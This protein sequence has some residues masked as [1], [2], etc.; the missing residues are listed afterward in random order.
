MRIYFNKI[1]LTFIVGLLSFS[2]YAINLTEV[3]KGVVHKID[4]IINTSSKDLT[5]KKIASFVN[6]FRRSGDYVSTVIAINKTLDYF[7][8]TNLDNTQ[9]KEINELKIALGQ[10]YIGLGLYAKSIKYNTEVLLYTTQ[11]RDTVLMIYSKMILSEAYMESK[12]YEKGRSHMIEAYQLSKI[13]KKYK[14]KKMV[15][16]NVAAM[17][18]KHSQPDSAIVYLNHLESLEKRDKTMDTYVYLNKCDCLL[19]QKK[20]DSALVYCN[21]F[22]KELKHFKNEHL[23]LSLNR[24]FAKIYIALGDSKKAEFHTNKALDKA[25]NHKYYKDIPEL[26]QI[27]IKIKKLQNNQKEVS[28]YQNKY[29][30]LKDSLINL[31]MKTAIS[32]IKLLYDIEKEKIKISELKA[33]NRVKQLRELILI[34]SLFVSLIIGFIFFYQK[35]KIDKAYKKIVEEN[36]KSIDHYDEFFIQRKQAIHKVEKNITNKE[37]LKPEL[38]V[39]LETQIRKAFDEDEVFLNSNLDLTSFANMLDTNKVYLSHV[40]NNIMNISFSEML[41]RYRINKAKKLL[42]LNNKKFTIESIALES[43]FSNKATFNRNFKSLT[44]VTPSLFV[45]I[46]LEESV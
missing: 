31:N 46:A 43:G 23:E 38:A 11:S 12:E 39:E 13:S 41:N 17:Y 24:L 1:V 20:I 40:F 34:I 35:R 10:A 27:L 33:K 7:E 15:L 9:L 28:Y 6:E 45:K 16:G 37:I 32:N 29:I 4:S 19:E 14:R 5:I 8:N 30:N 22:K 18:L 3:R 36:I 21:L 42:L 2:L 26:F 44:G 25:K